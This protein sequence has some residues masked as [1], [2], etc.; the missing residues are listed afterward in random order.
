MKRYITTRID[1]M[2]ETEFGAIALG[3]TFVLG[4][5]VGAAAAW[6]RRRKRR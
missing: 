1:A 2:G 3:V 6:G 4:A 5:L